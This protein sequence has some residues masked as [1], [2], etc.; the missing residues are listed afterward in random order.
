M[1]DVHSAQAIAFMCSHSENKMSSLVPHIPKDHCGN[2]NPYAVLRGP[3]STHPG[4]SRE[5]FKAMKVYSLNGM[6]E[7]RIHRNCAV[8]K[9]PDKRA[10]CL[11]YGSAV[12]EHQTDLFARVQQKC[13]NDWARLSPS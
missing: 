13:A 8:Y 2:P 10:N 1:S 6:E 4:F 3:E 12:T 11:A 7:A 9:N 5:C